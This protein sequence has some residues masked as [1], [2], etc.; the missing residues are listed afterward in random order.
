M[1][2][3]FRPFACLAV[4][5]GGAMHQLPVGDRSIA[6]TR[7]VPPI[8]VRGG[9]GLRRFVQRRPGGED[10]SLGLTISRLGGTIPMISRPDRR[11]HRIVPDRGSLISRIRYPVTGVSDLV[12]EIRS[13]VTG[14]SGL[15][16]A[17]C[18]PLLDVVRSCHRPY[19]VAHPGTSALL[20]NAGGRFDRRRSQFRT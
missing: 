17:V 3:G 18:P 6:I 7:R 13:P 20:V 2:V 4:R 8:D 14:V 16:A 1:T 10:T 12:P 9:E 11:S 15:V 5:S 19:L